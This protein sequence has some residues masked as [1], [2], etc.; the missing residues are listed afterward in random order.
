MPDPKKKIMVKVLKP[1]PEKEK[2]AT[3][4]AKTA[5][6]PKSSAPYM[7]KVRKENAA[8]VENTGTAE[9]TKDKRVFRPDGI[10]LKIPSMT[11]TGEVNTVPYASSTKGLVSKSLSSA[12]KEA[13]NRFSSWYSDPATKEKF[14]KNTG[15]D[16]ERTTDLV[17]KGLKTPIVKYDEKVAH[18]VP[19]HPDASAEYR[20]PKVSI[21]LGNTKYE[22]T[23][24][25]SYKDEGDA[26]NSA[27]LNHE[28][29]HA[30]GL[31]TTL[32]PALYRALGLKLPEKNHSMMDYMKR[33]EEV[34]GNF[35]ELRMEL[36]LKPGQKVDVDSLQ[37]AVKDKN[38]NNNFW[39]H[40]SGS[41]DEKGNRDPKEVA[42][43]VKAINTIAYNSKK[44]KGNDFA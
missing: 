1:V 25:I 17:A 5:E 22:K 36:G 43:I 39:N 10:S 16:P 6:K 42:K 7:V 11:N 23:G 30:S 26:A 15:F 38:I 34:Y 24:F 8:K 3:A 2:F 14:Q 12:E 4:E 19:M 44:S 33:P 27:N 35:H 37:K 40:Y 20:S 21:N 28:L 18:S 31:D 32:A 29:V 9:N 13:S 41:L